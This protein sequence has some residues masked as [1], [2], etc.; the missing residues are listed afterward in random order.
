[1]HVA[2]AKESLHRILTDMAGELEAL[3]TERKTVMKRIAA[4]KSAVASFV[5]LSDDPGLA[6]EVARVL[7]LPDR[8]RKNGLTQACRSILINSPVPLT[9]REVCDSAS[10]HVKHHQ[11]PLASVTTI[12][13]RL[14]EYGEAQIVDDTEANRYR[15]QST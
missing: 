11:D 2:Y 12:L 1:M 14:V 5:E 8:Q 15:W 7:A 3:Y 6:E 9:A 10:E 4:I 13:N